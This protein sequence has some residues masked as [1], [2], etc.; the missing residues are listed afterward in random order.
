MTRRLLEVC[1]EDARGIAA[2]V[3][4]GADRIELCAALDIGGLTPPASLVRAAA[5]APLPVHLLARPRAGGFVHDTAERALVADDIRTAAEAGLAGVVIGASLS[6]HRLDA[7]TLSAWI[8]L[9]RDLGAARGQ[10]LSLTLHRVFDLAPDLAAALETAVALG[11]D[12]ILTSGG[13]PKAVDAIPTLTTLVDRAAGRI[14]ILAGSGVSAATLPAILASGIS[15]AHASC[16]SAV[17]EQD[18]ALTRFGFN[19]PVARQTD[20]AAVATLATM[21]RTT[22]T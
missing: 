10:P 19:P 15:E 16:R 13:Q 5:Q 14:G 12:R 8:A 3:A 6:D 9:A 4:G 11:F 18:P 22:E 21:L 20:I 1:V 2:A 7:E 17:P